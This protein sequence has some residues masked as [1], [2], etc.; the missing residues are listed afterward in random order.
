MERQMTA[1]RDRRAVI[2]KSEGIKESKVN[3]AEGIR[4]EIINISEAEMQSRINES[5][6][7]S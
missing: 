6:R 1:E 3:D 4:A 2:A 5:G 7:F